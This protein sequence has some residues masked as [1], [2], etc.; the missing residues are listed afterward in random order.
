[1]PIATGFRDSI[2]A[3]GGTSNHVSELYTMGRALARRLE[4]PEDTSCLASGASFLPLGM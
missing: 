3:Y 4:G 2:Y 1:M